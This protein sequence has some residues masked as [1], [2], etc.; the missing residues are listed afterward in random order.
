MQKLN[1]FRPAAL[2]LV[3]AIML[4][5]ATAQAQGEFSVGTRIFSAGLI[6]GGSGGT[7]L[8]AAFEVSTLELAPNIRLGLGGTAGYWSD[9]EPG[10]DVRVIPLLGNANVHVAIEEVPQLDLFAGVALGLVIS[11]VDVDNAA[12]D[13]D[14]SDTSLEFGINL[15][16]RYYFTNMVAGFVQLGVGDIPEIFVGLSFKF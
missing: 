8:G 15:G 16:A 1:L 4:P 11:S 10:F 14:E 9:S 5:F 13:V 7:G 3:A 6:T 2:A 12:V